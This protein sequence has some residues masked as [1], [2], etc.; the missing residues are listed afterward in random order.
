[1]TA[2]P[3]IFRCMVE[4]ADL[5]RGVAFY[6]S[7]LGQPGRAIRGGRHYFD[8][9]GVIFGLVDVAAG[10]DEAEAA[11]EPLYFAVDDL[12]QVHRRA[13]ELGCLSDE[14]VHGENAGTATVRPWGERSFYVRD[15]FGNALCFVDAKTLFT[16]Q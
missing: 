7:L 8:C 10:G 15:P 6:A 14:D 1:M 4:V 9:G 2:H 13:A 12:D 16:G 5:D 3:R 11:P